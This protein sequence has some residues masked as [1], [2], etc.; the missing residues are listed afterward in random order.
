VGAET[1][2]PEF[3][4]WNLRL[5]LPQAVNDRRGVQT[6]GNR[7]IFLDT[8]LF[9]MKIQMHAKIKALSEIYFGV[10]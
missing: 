1:I 9:Q 8:A 10:T 6:T 5:V 2:L 4:I 7:P 3:G